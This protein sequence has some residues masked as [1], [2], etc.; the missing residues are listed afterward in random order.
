MNDSLQASDAAAA[1]VAVAPRVTL[2]D[3]EA[4]IADKFYL[5]GGEFS[6]ASLAINGV[7][8]ALSR[9]QHIAKFPT[10]KALTLCVV[11]LHNGYTIV[12]KSAPA[13]PENF[14]AELGRKF[15]YEDAV[16][17]LWPL[18]GFLLRN[19]LW[20]RPHQADQARA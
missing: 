6:E 9:D 10:L 20:L 12:G 5:T 15:S 8:D 14:N 16:R 4:A 1:A 18:M 2:A 19:D 7:V 3:I 13:A 17:Q 11:V